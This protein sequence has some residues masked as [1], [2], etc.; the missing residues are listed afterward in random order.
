MGK[1]S[2]ANLFGMTIR[3]S[4]NDGS[5]FTN[6]DADYRRLFL[7]EDGLLHLKDSAGT[8]TTPAQGGIAATIVDAKGDLIAATAADTVS[9]LAVGTNGHVL[10]ADSAESTGIKW[11]AASGGGGGFVEFGGVKL[12]GG[13]GDITTTSTTFVDL[14]GA[15]VT[16]TTAAVRCLVMFSANVVN[17]N[18]GQSAFFDV[19]IDG[20]RYANTTNGMSQTAG[21]TGNWHIA[22]TFMTDVLSA[23]SHTFKVQWRVSANT[24]GV[25]NQTTTSPVVFQVI[26]TNLAT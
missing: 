22:F 24:G 8:V 26:E 16:M 20:T 6:P 5:D 21:G 12:T 23:A 10:T 13:G 15:S 17:S 14:T 11:A 2:L 18:A 19:D 4:A 3:E 25:D 1:F 9:R 7:G